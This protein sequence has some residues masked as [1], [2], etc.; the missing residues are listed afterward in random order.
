MRT[1]VVVPTYEEAANIPELLP[2]LR[3]AAPQVD[4]LVVDDNSP[5]G[6]AKLAQELNEELGQIEVLVRGKKAGLGT[7]YRAGFAIGIERG[8]DVLVQMDADLSHDP[9]AVPSLLAALGDDV[10]MVIGSRYVPGGRIPHWPWHRR[11]LSRYGNLYT[12][13][14]LGMKAR[15]L[16]SGFRAWKATTLQGIDYQTTHATGYLFQ[17]EMAYRVAQLGEQ[18]A[19]VPIT[20]TDRVRGMS[21]MSGAVVFEELTRVTWWGIRDRVRRLL[22]AKSKTR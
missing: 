12:R 18:I 15:D 8:Y 21:K 9:S 1:L 2:R 14:A 3:A 13:L 19:E 20:F 10:G 22:H 7:A 16:T 5:D 4:I 17:M 6:T 11:F